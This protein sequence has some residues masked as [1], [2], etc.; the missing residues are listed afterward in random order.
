MR[1]RLFGYHVKIST[2]GFLVLGGGLVGLIILVFVIS[3]VWPSSKTTPRNFLYQPAF[4]SQYVENAT[5]KAGWLGPYESAL[6]VFRPA[7]GNDFSGA[8][9]PTHVGRPMSFEVYIPDPSQYP[10]Y[11]LN[12]FGKDFVPA[13]FIAPQQSTDLQ[14]LGATI[15]P[16]SPNFMMIGFPSGQK[17]I[18]GHAYD[19]KGL[20]WWRS[21]YLVYSQTHASL[22]Q[23]SI[24]PVFLADGYDAV[25][26]AQLRA[27]ATQTLDLELRY[28]EGGQQLTIH[29]VE[30]SAGKEVRL[31]VTVANLTNSPIQPWSGI[32]QATASLPQQASVTGTPDADGPFGSLN[33]LEAQQAVTGYIVFDQSVADPQQEL[34]IRMPPLSLATNTAA[35]SDLIILRVQPG[36]SVSQSGGQTSTQTTT[37]ATSG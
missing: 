7:S 20:L 21:D 13:V 30:W 9:F 10:A 28:A 16:S 22:Q 35:T 29:R 14:T 8:N 12:A 1:V 37:A 31:L 15:D 27:P 24:A 33:Q 18:A 17:P 19:V 5:A 36:R 3:A 26:P 23:Q 4:A 11:T 25:E 34:T 32:Q 2:T 6:G